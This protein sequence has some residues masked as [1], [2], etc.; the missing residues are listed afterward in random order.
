MF[1]NLHN[2]LHYLSTI[3]DRVS[4]SSP[5][6]PC[7]LPPCGSSP[8]LSCTIYPSCKINTYIL[9]VRT[10]CPYVWSKVKCPIL[11]EESCNS[12]EKS[13]KRYYT[14]H[15]VCVCC[16]C[17]NT[18]S[19]LFYTYMNAGKKQINKQIGR[20]YQNTCTHTCT[21]KHTLCDIHIEI[22][23]ARFPKNFATCEC[24]CCAQGK[25]WNMYNI[26]G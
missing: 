10:V 4:F 16:V 18:H 13:F 17:S 1:G 12:A 22:I 26:F 11:D 3:T 24:V 2:R 14:M 25:I 20:I 19:I 6:T 8:I 21:H 7:S 15:E 5:L 23:A 9:C